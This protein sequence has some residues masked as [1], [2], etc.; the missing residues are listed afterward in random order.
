V[1][2]ATEQY[3]EFLPSVDIDLLKT[4]IEVN[5]TR[6]FA[7][8]AEDLYVTSAAVSARVKQLESH[9]GVHVFVRNPVGSS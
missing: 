3:L 4:F 5:Q 6:N 1:Y 2:D 8:A 9:L 7:R